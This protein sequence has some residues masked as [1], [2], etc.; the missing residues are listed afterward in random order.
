MPDSQFAT[1]AFV[2]RVFY[3][4]VRLELNIAGNRAVAFSSIEYNDGVELEPIFGAGQQPLGVGEG[5]YN[6][7]SVKI[8][9]LLEDFERVLLPTLVPDPATGALYNHD[10]IDANLVYGN[11]AGATLVKRKLASIRFNKFSEKAAEGD[12]KIVTSSEGLILGGIW[13]N[14]I[15]PVAN[16]LG[17]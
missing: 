17:Q 5:N 10:P 14:G 1:G 11:G 9:W 12:K 7:M 16:I 6:E 15:K 8:D 2:N 4:F 13:R 3:S